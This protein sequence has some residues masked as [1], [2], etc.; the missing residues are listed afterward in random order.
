MLI[1]DP[2]EGVQVTVKLSTGKST[3]PHD[4][5]PMPMDLELEN[6]NTETPIAKVGHHRSSLS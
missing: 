3:V 1:T 2:T 6:E 5:D 4:Q